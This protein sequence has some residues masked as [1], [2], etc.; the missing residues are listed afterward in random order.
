MN[1]LQRKS[2]PGDDARRDS[3]QTLLACGAH[4]AIGARDFS[5]LEVNFE[6]YGRVRVWDRKWKWKRGAASFRTAPRRTYT[7]QMMESTVDIDTTSP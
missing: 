4:L 5:N 1:N 7:K 6:F 2:S 3:N